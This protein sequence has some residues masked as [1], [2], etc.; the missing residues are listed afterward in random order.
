MIIYEMERKKT[1]VLLMVAKGTYQTEVWVY[2]V[3]ETA[4]WKIAGNKFV[5]YIQKISVYTPKIM[6]RCYMLAPAL[7]S[8]NLI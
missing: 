8:Y 6:C 5:K 1:K 2:L 3:I 4:I 7:T